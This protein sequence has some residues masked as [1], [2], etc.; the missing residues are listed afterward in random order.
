MK[1]GWSMMADDGTAHETA[2]SRS[3]L[4]IAV[5]RD[6]A[7]DIRCTV[8][9][10]LIDIHFGLAHSIPNGLDALVGLF[11]NDL[12]EVGSWLCR[13]KSAEQM[14]KRVIVWRNSSAPIMPS[15]ETRCAR[16]PRNGGG[17]PRTL[18]L[19]AKILLGNLC[20]KAHV[21]KNR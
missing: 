14:R 15:Y 19:G 1:A 4:W 20:R 3:F 9:R 5:W 12:R 10:L 16:L 17:S 7:A 13:Q 21:L 18:R 6:G 11:T 8:C 2:P